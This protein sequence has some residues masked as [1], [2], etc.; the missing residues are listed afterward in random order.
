MPARIRV[1]H[2]Y[3]DIDAG[4]GV[5]TWIRSLMGDPDA[6]FDQTLNQPWDRQPADR[7]HR[8]VHLHDHRRTAWLDEYRQARNRGAGIVT[9]I[10]NHAPYCPSQ[11]KFFQRM[12]RPCSIAMSPGG[13]MASRFLMRCGRR[14]PV[15]AVGE[16]RRAS[17]V[18]EV[19]RGGRVQTLV[20]TE[21]VRR[22]LLDQGVP[23]PV[24]GLAP[25][26]MT[27]AD[28]PAPAPPPEAPPRLL[29]TGRLSPDKGLS[30]LIDALAAADGE[31]VLDVAGSGDDEH[32]ARRRV[33]ELGLA[34]RVTFHGWVDAPRVR[35]LLARCWVAVV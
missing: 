27:S 29:F 25:I 20:Y 31:V 6:P 22:Q 21:F 34:A 23:D 8:V 12:G 13:C 1:D 11:S 35:E 5:R 4:G 10:H 26:P 15:A 9:T 28:W 14:N 33:E 2:R 30:W 32:H 3:A 16:F 18:L 19:L 17:A 24:I 7:D